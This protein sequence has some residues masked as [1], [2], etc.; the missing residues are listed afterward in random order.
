MTHVTGVRLH[1]LLSGWALAIA[2]VL[3][4]FAGVARAGELTVTAT[5]EAGKPLADAVIFLDSPAAKAASKAVGGVEIAQQDRKFLPPVTVLPV[6]SSIT[7]PNRDTVRHHVYSFSPAKTFDLKLYSGTPSAPVLFDK[8]GVVNLGC[9]IHDQMQA[10]VVVVETP[11]Y[12]KSEHNGAA[13]LRAVPAGNYRLKVWHARLPTN[14]PLYEQAITVGASAQ[15][16][17]V[18]LKGLDS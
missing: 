3:T 1:A 6:G 11:F 9:N 14:A 8:P 12:G 2:G 5:D 17:T 15:Q 7:F 16:Q 10:W 4:V 13:V 18:V